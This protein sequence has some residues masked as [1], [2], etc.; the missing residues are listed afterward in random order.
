MNQ[1][2]YEAG[3]PHLYSVETILEFG[4]IGSR[5]AEIE[6]EEATQ[7]HVRIVG[8]WVTFADNGVCN[9]TA[10]LDDDTLDEVFRIAEVH[11]RER[12]SE[13]DEMIMEGDR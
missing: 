4:C 5:L 2:Q 11:R 9:I 6:Y 13:L 12:V 1:Q 10:Y 7:S 3:I 8:V